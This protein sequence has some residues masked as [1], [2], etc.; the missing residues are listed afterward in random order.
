[1]VIVTIEEKHSIRISMV[2]LQKANKRLFMIIHV[3][4]NLNYNKEKEN[5][6]QWLIP[7]M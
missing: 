7:Y 3:V 6:S 4:T 5:A 2:K 1:M